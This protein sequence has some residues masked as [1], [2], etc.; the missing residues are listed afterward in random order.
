M[1]EVRDLTFRHSRHAP[2][3]ID[4]VSFTAGRA[5]MTLILGA[6]GSGKTTIFNCITGLWKPQRGG[7]FFDGE[8]M[9]TFSWKRRAQTV[10]VVPQEHEPPFAYSV[11]DA[12]LVGR[13]SRVSAVSSPSRADYDIARGAIETVGISSLADRPYTRIS[14][15][16][17]QLVLVARAIAQEAPVLILDEPTSHLDLK[18][19]LRVMDTVRDIVERKGLTVLMTL[20]DPNLA[21]SYS[22]AVV[23]IGG[24]RVLAAGTPLEVITKENLARMYGIDVSVIDLDGKRVIHSGRELCSR[25]KN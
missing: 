7:V 21:L 24:G 10:A 22:D 23:M 13:V 4:G 8:D 18:N 25:R 17:R 2:P 3:V 11:L 12:V 5:G 14:G 15:G 1:M 6:N 9:S 19:Q 20:H 16:E